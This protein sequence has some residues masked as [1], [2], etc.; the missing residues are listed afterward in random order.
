LNGRGHSDVAPLGASSLFLA[1]W[2]EFL[3]AI[4]LVLWKKIGAKPGRRATGKSFADR[5]SSQQIFPHFVLLSGALP[6]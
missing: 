4:C 2:A 5:N 3:S 6:A 1:F